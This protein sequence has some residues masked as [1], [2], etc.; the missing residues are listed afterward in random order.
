MDYLDR[1]PEQ[2]PEVP[3]GRWGTLL[4]GLCALAVISLT[5]GVALAVTIALELAVLRDAG[6]P[7]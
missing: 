6:M 7:S 1:R 2:T 5:A 3:R 4:Q